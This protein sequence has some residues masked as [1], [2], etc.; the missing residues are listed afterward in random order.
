MNNAAYV[1]TLVAQMK[2]QGKTKTE[3]VIASAEA[4]VGWPYVW[5]ATGQDCTPA[6]RE[7][8]LKRESE[9]EASVTVKKC[10][11]LNGTKASCDRCKYYPNG[12]RT[13]MEDCQGFIKK[14]LKRIGITMKG[15][16]CSSM[17]KDN[18]NWTQKGEIDTLPEKLC[19]VFWQNSKNKS[20]MEHIGFYIGNGYMIHCSGEVKKEKLSKKCTHWAIPVGLEGEIPVTFPTLRKGSK[21]EYVTL[22]QTKLIQQGY[23]LEPYGADGSFGAKT[24]SAVKAFQKNHNL[25]ADGIVGPKT[26]EALNNTEP[27]EWY[28]VTV[29][30]LT[31]EQA[32]ALLGQYPDAVR[33]KEK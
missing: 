7:A 11:V 25:N 31:P 19:C 20:V 8:F 32:N 3:I 1:D 23:D 21:G 29:P 4:C 10:Q 15:G 16:G 12:C 6:K 28:T 30:H 22:L 33:T 14:I 9:A 13:L 18:S 17:W 26:W 2:T 5:G 27:T 24:Q